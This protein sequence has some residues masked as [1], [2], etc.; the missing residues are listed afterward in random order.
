MNKINWV[1]FLHIYQPPWQDRGVIEQAA[2]ESYD[3]LL[4]LL[5]KYPKFTAS[6]NITGSLLEQLADIRPDLLKRLQG[7]VKKNKIE[8]VGSAKYHA[9]LPLL[10]REEVV[11]QIKLS[12]EVLAKY[13]SKKI[14]GFY[15]PEMA[16]SQEVGKII[17]G[18]GY[19]W[20]IL[21]AINYQQ[22]VD[23]KI[24]YEIKNI[25]L[26]VVFRDRKISKSY[27]AEV[28][29]QKLQATDIEK[30]IIITGT[31]GEMYGHFHE[32]WQG[33]LEKILKNDN[34]QVQTV[35]QYL[36]NL[37]QT[38]KIDLR[39]A[40]WETT[41]TELKKR[42]PFALWQHPKNKI[43]LDLWKLVDLAIRIVRENKRDQNYKWSR[44]HLDR[45]LSSCTFWWA[46]ATKPSDFSPLTWNPDMIDNGS[47][48]LIR[49]IRSLKKVAANQRIKAERLY[50]Q[51]KKNTWETH[52]R[53]HH[54]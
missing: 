36:K 24:S 1:N 31:D 39:A 17:K 18:Q 45:G 26:K 49:S 4:T 8:L 10:P 42:I 11:R 13:F 20:I 51:I 54:K 21:D 43:H 52:W 16:Y 27:P 33:H 41:E 3:Y 7:L 5:E 25:G 38:E 12:Q 32:D 23:N 15:L 47:E 50:I 6:L 19:Q 34:L 35:G 9:L 53:K 37:K 22:S 2:I 28:I 40:S 30:S 48:E 14:T 46:S 29:Y 44:W